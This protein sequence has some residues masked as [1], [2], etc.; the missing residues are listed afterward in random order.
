MLAYMVAKGI[1]HVCE[2]KHG[3]VAQRVRCWNCNRRPVADPS[4]IPQRGG[5]FF[6]Y[7]ILQYLL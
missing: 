5:V 3:S 2:Q 7:D 6:I 4:S 1:N